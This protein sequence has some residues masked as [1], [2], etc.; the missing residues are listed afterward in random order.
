VRG[1]AGGLLGGLA[2]GM[3]TV[4]VVGLESDDVARS[5]IRFKGLYVL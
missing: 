4:A 2:R 1:G 5:G 3:V